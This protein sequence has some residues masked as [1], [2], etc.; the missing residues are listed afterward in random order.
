MAAAFTHSLTHSFISLGARP[1]AGSPSTASEAGG[2]TRSD[3]RFS[4][5]VMRYGEATSYGA[6]SP[7]KGPLGRKQEVKRE[8]FRQ[9]EQKVPK[10]RETSQHPGGWKTVGRRLGLRMRW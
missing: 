10:P 9:R 7:E 3:T 1:W 6:R 4:S 8:S 2:W 5:A